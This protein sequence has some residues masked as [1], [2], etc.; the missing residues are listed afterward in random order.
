MKTVYVAFETKSGLLRALWNLRLRGDEEEAPVGERAWY[1]EV[2]EKPDPAQ[3]LRL[4][5]ENSRAVK[6]RA[7]AL[8]EVI[9]DA[10]PSDPEVA[11]LWRRI[12]GDFYENQLAIV[13][14]LDEGALRDNLDA[15]AAGDLLWTLNHPSVYWLLIGRGWSPERY[16]EWLVDALQ[17]QLLKP[18]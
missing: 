10:A 6:E 9:R 13:K 5:A 12:E 11:T 1:L 8:M 14:S 15:E 4:N 17:R 3:K 18:D 7:G 2:L 16:E